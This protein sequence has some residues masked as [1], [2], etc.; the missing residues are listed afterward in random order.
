MIGRTWFEVMRRRIGLR[1]LRVQSK[2]NIADL[3]SRKD[4]VLLKT[5]GAEEMQPCLPTWLSS[6]WEVPNFQPF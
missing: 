1:L 2:A 6:L 3:P 4:F 5:M